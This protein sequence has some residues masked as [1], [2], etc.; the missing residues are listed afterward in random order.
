MLDHS[1]FY[2]YGWCSVLEKKSMDLRMDDPIIEKSSWICNIFHTP[3]DLF[4]FETYNPGIY[5]WMT[6]SLKVQAGNPTFSMGINQN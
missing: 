4:M 6:L 5:L 2:P 3:M 1:I